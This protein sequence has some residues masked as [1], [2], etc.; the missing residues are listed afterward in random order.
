MSDKIRVVCPNCQ[1]ALSV[2]AGRAGTRGRCPRNGCGAVID[3]PARSAAAAPVVLELP[4]PDPEIELKAGKDRKPDAAAPRRRRAKKPD[5]TGEPQGWNDPP[6]RYQRLL[7]MTGGQEPV[8]LF[9]LRQVWLVKQT[10]GTPGAAALAYLVDLVVCDT[11]LLILPFA[12]MAQ[13]NLLGAALLTGFVGAVVE[14]DRAAEA[15]AKATDAYDE[16]APTFEGWSAAERF[17][18]GVR[19]RSEVTAGMFTTVADYAEFLPADEIGAWGFGSDNELAIRFRGTEYQF[20]QGDRPTEAT[21]AEWYQA[22]HGLEALLAAGK[23]SLRSR[24]GGPPRPCLA[25]LVEWAQRPPRGTPAWVE[26]AVAAGDTT[27][28]AAVRLVIRQAGHTAVRKLVRRLVASQDLVGADQLVRAIRRV[29][30]R[31]ARYLMLGGLAA[32]LA[33]VGWVAGVAFADSAGM[34]GKDNDGLA[35]ATGLGVV[36]LL[37]GAITCVAAG[38]HLRRQFSAAGGNS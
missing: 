2:P 35:I 16:L 27:A 19:I 20:R 13:R 31:T 3:I 36:V 24:S 26:E 37:F 14:A 10:I 33:A 1:A 23:E 15:R 9:R 6:A 11:G 12:S 7:V 30:L 8:E 4:E 25:A 21:H 28:P 17:I 38:F 32:F 34:I 5:P 18:E 22:F 29:A